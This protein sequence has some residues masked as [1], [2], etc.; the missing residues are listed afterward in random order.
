[1]P[2]ILKIRKKDGS[3]VLFSPQKARKTASLACSKYPE[4]T[5]PDLIIKELTRNIFDGASTTDIERALILSSTAFIENDPDYGK[6][7]AQLFLQRLYKEAMKIS[8]N[9]TTLHEEYK[10]TFINGTIFFHKIYVIF[11]KI[12]YTKKIFFLCL[13]MA[14][15]FYFF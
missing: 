3:T 5:S 1:M 7:S 4:T 8:I 11:C 6:V 13:L 12:T 10:K 2:N 14:Y 15:I 9:E